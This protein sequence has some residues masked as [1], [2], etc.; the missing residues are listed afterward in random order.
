[1]EV[2]SEGRAHFSSEELVKVLSH[3]DTGVVH[4]VTLLAGGDRRAPK[5]VVTAEKGTFLLKRRP[6]G[7]DNLARV[8]FAHMI[9]KHLA[10][11]SFPVTALMATVDDGVTALSL[12]DH[13]YEFFRFVE[14]SRCDGSTQATGEAGRQL[15]L[16]H[17]HL[18]RVTLPNG[19]GGSN[20]SPGCADACYHDSTT[21]RRHLKL[22]S[23]GRRTGSRHKARAV[24]ESLLIRY[25]RSSDRV[26]RFGFAT[27]KRQVI[28]GDWHP[29]NL[30]FS[31]GRI[32]A[33]LDFD[34]IRVAPPPTDLANGML[35]FSIVGDQTDPAA[36]PDH[37]DQGRL[38]EFLNGYREVTRLSQR[39]LHS[40]MDLMVETMVAEAVLPVA[41][42]GFFGQHSGLSFLDMIVRKTKWLRRHRKELTQAM[43]T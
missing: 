37:F 32:V 36:W 6:R 29:G 3:Y 30:L 34:S 2:W 14:G 26:N 7:R 13:I 41:A 5:V 9:Q 21:V 1:M 4:R 35:Q 15:A 12:E 11:R 40:L 42:T 16:F 43:L 8:A 24:V 17:K 27:W 18:A 22:I 10:E 39:K 20:G 19:E 31:G 28:H 23:S 33:V 38:L 25:D